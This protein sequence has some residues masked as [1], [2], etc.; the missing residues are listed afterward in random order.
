MQVPSGR[1]GEI[2]GRELT[3]KLSKSDVFHALPERQAL[4]IW[5]RDLRVPAAIQS[6]PTA[7]ADWVRAEISRPYGSVDHIR[8]SHFASLSRFTIGGGEPT[9]AKIQA[10]QRLCHFPAGRRLIVQLFAEINR[11]TPALYV[12]EAESLPSRVWEHLTG[13]SDFSRRLTDQMDLDWDRLVLHYFVLPKIPKPERRD[14]A[15]E[16]RT[17][18]EYVATRLAIGTSVSRIG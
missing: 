7:L 15:K 17:L 6:S 14:S 11:I 1:W 13:Q 8:I 10:L 12:G 2:L 16:M 3:A 18:L 4:Y 5:K 9:E